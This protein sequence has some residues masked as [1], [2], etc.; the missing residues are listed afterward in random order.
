MAFT[1]LS[2][3]ICRSKCMPCSLSF[4]ST[5]HDKEHSKAFTF[6]T[7][8]NSLTDNTVTKIVGLDFR[9]IKVSVDKLRIKKDNCLVHLI[10]KL[11]NCNNNSVFASN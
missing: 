7:N 10:K 3:T 2:V 4:Y 5:V 11:W 6:L 1:I 9:I 8:S